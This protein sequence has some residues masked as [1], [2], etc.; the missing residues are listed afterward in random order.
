MKKIAVFL[1]LIILLCACSEEYIV[2]LDE[3]SGILSVDGTEYYPLE[4]SEQFASSGEM[5]KVGAV[6]GTDV[7]EAGENLYYADGV[8]YLNAENKA[9]SKPFEECEAF[10]YIPYESLEDFFDDVKFARNAERLTDTEAQDFSFYA[11]YGRTP[12]E[13]GYEK[14]EYAGQLF[15]A[16]PEYDDFYTSYPVYR[17]SDSDYS[18][19]IDGEE[20]ILEAKWAKELGILD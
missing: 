14:G 8:Y 7:Y 1:F 15:G 16:F 20:Y 4:S 2:K 5:K 13:F 19:E 17:Y 12:E 10:F 18:V 6:F 3:D 11:L 9:F